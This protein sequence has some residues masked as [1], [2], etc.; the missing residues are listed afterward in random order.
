MLH[1]RRSVVVL[2]LAVLAAVAAPAGAAEAPVE[3]FA[4]YQPQHFCNPVAKPGTKVLEAW[5]VRS[6]GGAQGAISRPCSDGGVSEH[7]E[8]RAFDW[9]LDATKASDRARARAFRARL[10]AVG[11]S[12]QPA[13]LARRMGVMYLIWNDHIFAAYDHFVARPYLSSGCKSV[14]TC[15]RT[16]RH[17][18]HLHVS[19]SRAGG[20][21]RTSWYAGKVPLSAQYPAGQAPATTP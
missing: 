16:L 1:V 13:E 21:G 20:W 6:F 14:R 8:G 9:T 7:K 2:T 4:R 5:T 19:L 18:D 15:S 17:R 12:G 10:F 11:P 3:P